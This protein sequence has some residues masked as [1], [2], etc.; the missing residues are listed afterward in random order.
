ML[1][2]NSVLKNYLK[3]KF[4]FTNLSVMLLNDLAMAMAH[5]GFSQFQNSLEEFEASMNIANETGDRLLE[6]QIC[7][8]LGSL[9]T[10]LR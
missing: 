8:G 1:G 7:V 9:F 2:R 3:W 10:L 5:L 4:K 6:L